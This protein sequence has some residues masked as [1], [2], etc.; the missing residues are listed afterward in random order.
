[1]RKTVLSKCSNT[2]RQPNSTRK[3]RLSNPTQPFFKQCQPTPIRVNPR[4]TVSTRTKPCQPASNHA[5]PGQSVSTPANPCQP[6]PT[7]SQNRRSHAKNLEKTTAKAT[8]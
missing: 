4:Q 7:G 3:F 8:R 6:A 5:N 1:M 2:L